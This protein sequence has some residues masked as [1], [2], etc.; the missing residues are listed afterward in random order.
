MHTHSRNICCHASTNPHS[1]AHTTKQLKT[2]ITAWHTHSN[3]SPHILSTL[4]NICQAMPTCTWAQCRK[5]FIAAGASSK[6]RTRTA[7][8]VKE[9]KGWKLR[10]TRPIVLREG[11]QLSQL[12]VWVVFFHWATHQWG[13]VSGSTYWQMKHEKVDLFSFFFLQYS[14]LSDSHLRQDELPVA[15]IMYN[16]T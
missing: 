11:L 1:S 10:T 2:Q 13:V 16:L 9:R 3:V 12:C 8:F 5:P 6:E 4:S 15:S 14:L 7:L